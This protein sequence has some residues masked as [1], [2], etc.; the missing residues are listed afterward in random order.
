MGTARSELFVDVEWLASHLGTPGL[1]VVDASWHMPASGRDGLAEYRTGHIPGAVFFDIDRIADQSSPLPHMLPRPEAF[2]SAMRRLGIGDGQSIVVYDNAGLMSAPRVWWTFRVMGVRDVRILDGGL[3]AWTAAGHWLE[4][5]EVRRGE[6]HFTAR[7]DNSAVRN[8]Q[9]MQSLVANGG[10]Q[11]LDARGRG[12]FEGSEAEPR[13]G[14]RG[15]H[16]PGAIN[17]PWTELVL[18][19]RLKSEKVLGEILAARGI[20]PARPTVTTCG[21][22]V[23][24][25]VLAL[26]VLAAGGRQ[27]ALYDGS[28]TEWGGRTDT[29]VATGP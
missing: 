8:L 5:G 19:G 20:D 17:L 14:L 13:P 4:D 7:L 28:W 25:A 23:T 10:V 16:M 18:D 3:A 1:V 22:G 24:A 6:R 26:A 9:E 11:I 29:P 15:G 21:S 12:R 27:P 2:S